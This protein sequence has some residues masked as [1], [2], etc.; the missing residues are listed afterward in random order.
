MLVKSKYYYEK[1][2]KL[3]EYFNSY[4]YPFKYFFINF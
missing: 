2:K 4:E 3:D 1:E